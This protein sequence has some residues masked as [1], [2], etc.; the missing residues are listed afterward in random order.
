MIP[1][2][3]KDDLGGRG[4]WQG[5]KCIQFEYN[6]FLIHKTYFKSSFRFTAKWNGGASQ[7]VQW[8]RL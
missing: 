3:E 4:S 1:F 2:S 6:Y 8:L 7:V 5:E